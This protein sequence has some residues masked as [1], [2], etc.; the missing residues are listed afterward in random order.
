MVSYGLSCPAEFQ[1]DLRKAI[2]LL[3]IWIGKVLPVP[4]E[5]AAQCSGKMILRIPAGRGVHTSCENESAE[6]CV[7]KLEI[8]EKRYEI[9]KENM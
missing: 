1:K 9:L 7:E 3:Q 6:I 5:D 2:S 8:L 4:S